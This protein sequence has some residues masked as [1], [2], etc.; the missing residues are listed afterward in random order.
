LHYAGRHDEAARVA[1]TA[2]VEA[3]GCG[4][5]E[6]LVHALLAS[7]QVRVPPMRADIPVVLER[8]EELFAMHDQLL[9]IDPIVT[10]AEYAVVSNLVAGDMSAASLWRERQRTLES[11][12]SSR[13]AYFV[14]ICGDQIVAFLHGELDRAESLANDA[15]E[16]GR[17]TGEDV[18]GIHGVQ[19]FLIRREQ[20][21]LAELAPVVRL[22]LGT[23]PD[24]LL[25]GPGLALLL[26]EMGMYDE[27]RAQLDRLARDDFAALPRDNLFPAACCFLTETAMH[28]GDGDV[29]RAVGKLLE[30]WDGLGVSLGHFVGHLGAADR[31]RALSAWVAGDIDAADTLLDRAIAWNRRADAFVWL[32]HTLVDRAGLLQRAGDAATAAALASDARVLAVRHELVAVAHRLDALDALG[33]E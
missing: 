29:A 1:E 25:W 3:R 23:N 18:S 4:D 10:V 33:A 32:A 2:L 28:V 22:F 26:A 27:A 15:I 16:F 11:R 19:M 17:Q 14:T 6:T 30:P 8:S 13:F 20:D 12:Q 5:R 31:Y 24:A 7:V 9:D 21:R